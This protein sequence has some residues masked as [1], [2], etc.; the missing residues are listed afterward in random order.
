MFGAVK[1]TKRTWRLAALAGLL[2]MVVAA[3]AGWTQDEAQGLDTVVP[4]F[5]ISNTDIREV[6]ILLSKFSN[7]NFT[8]TK[9]VKGNITVE[10][11]NVTVRDILESILKDNGFSYGET[12]GGIIRVMTLEQW[13]K[14]Y[15]DKVEIFDRRFNPRYVSVEDLQRAFQ[16]LL[17]KDGKM[18]VVK[19][20]NTLIVSDVSEVLAKVEKFYPLIDAQLLTRV[21]RLENIDV[22]AIRQQVEQLIEAKRGQIQ[23]DKERNIMILQTTQENLEKVARI[24]EEFDSP[25]EMEI[26]EIQFADPEDVMKLLKPLLTKEGYLELHEQTSKI[27]VRDIASRVEV[28]RELVASLDEPPKAVWIEAEILNVNMS[29]LRDIGVQ[30]SYGN[31]VTEPTGTQLSGNQM[32]VTRPLFNL[33]SGE[34]NYVDFT[35]L[36]QRNLAISINALESKGVG[37]ILASPRVLVINDKEADINIGSEEP[38]LVRQRRTTSA[39][40]DTDI[41]TQRTRRVGITLTVSP[42]IIPSGYVQMEVSMEDS[43]PRR[44]TI[45]NE[46]ALAVDQRTVDTEVIVKDGRTVALGG[47]IKRESTNNR[48]GVPILA[49]IPILGYP[50]RNTNTENKRQKLILFLTPRIVS[51]DDPYQKYQYDD[52]LKARMFEKDGVMEYMDRPDGEENKEDP[53]R[54]Y[55]ELSPEERAVYQPNSEHPKA[56]ILQ[57]GTYD[58]RGIFWTPGDVAPP[59]VEP[60]ERPAKRDAGSP[61][62][63]AG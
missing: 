54:W 53:D 33:L 22:D 52:S 57:P 46:E 51:V 6:L 58:E 8:T 32:T 43:T 17:S 1:G 14:E 21:F 24:I 50:F 23:I 29:K 62:G 19:A 4:T 13:N 48:S 16:P 55:Y 35:S 27:I 18:S 34:L 47:L 3:S 63:I 42:H 38:Y 41:F 2:A 37:K 12:P 31:E 40:D 20:T 15:G 45:G 61:G 26:F 5:S 9:E 44:V 49:N 28:A 60:M 39:N 11:S 10:L 59:S 36:G 7:L 30:W 25:L 56:P